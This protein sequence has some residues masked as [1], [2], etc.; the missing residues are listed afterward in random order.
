MV[1]QQCN[2]WNCCKSFYYW[3]SVWQTDMFDLMNSEFLWSVLMGSAR[4]YW[5]FYK[6]QW[7]GT[8]KQRQKVTVSI[9]YYCRHCFCFRCCCCLPD[10]CFLLCMFVFFLRMC[11]Y[12]WLWC[13]ATVVVADVICFMY[14][15]FYHLRKLKRKK[16]RKEIAVKVHS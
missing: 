1:P 8:A 16:E 6:W 4:D 10:V 14:F 3:W 15:V 9:P 7:L 13:T 11:C 2:N 5:L 12:L